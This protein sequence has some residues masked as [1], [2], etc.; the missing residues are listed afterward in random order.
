MVIRLVQLT[1]IITVMLVVLMGVTF[2][3]G[4]ETHHFETF[5]NV[6][7]LTGCFLLI[8]GIWYLIAPPHRTLSRKLNNKSS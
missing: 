7:Q 6:V 4:F 1:G 8:V 3:L 5:W 2:G